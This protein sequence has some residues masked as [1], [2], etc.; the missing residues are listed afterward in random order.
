MPKN[1]L[2]TLSDKNYLQQAK[3]L[4]SS[5]YWNAG[6]RGDYMLLACEV[7]E[8]ELQ[9]FR[10]KG[11]LVKEVKPFSDKVPEGGGATRYPATVACK[12]GLFSEEFKSWGTLVFI[13]A[14]CIVRYPLDSLAKTKGFAAARDWCATISGQIRKLDGMS[15]SEHAQLF[16]G[17]NPIAPAFNTGVFAFNTDII[18]N[19][20]QAKLKQIVDKYLDSGRFGEQL[21][22]NLYFYKKWTRLPMKY[23]LFATYLQ[24]KRG[25]S[26]KQVDGVVL[27]FPRFGD[28]EG[29]RCWDTNNPF[30]DEWKRNLDRADLI[31]LEHIP[32]PNRRWRGLRHLLFQGWR[33]RI[34]SDGGYLCFCRNKMA[35]RRRV[36]GLMSILRPS[37]FER[38]IFGR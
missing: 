10:E 2:V 4:F 8:P 36:R 27:H 32:T 23:N 22:I 24:T 17:Y 1:L 15:E 19:T 30:Y 37:S 12:L 31:D 35:V 9:W 18:D 29:F 26:E 21:C 16:N 38:D 11:I 34:A 6:W 7:P 14:D 20:T 33:L 5:V 28:E 25:L 13:D 3:Q